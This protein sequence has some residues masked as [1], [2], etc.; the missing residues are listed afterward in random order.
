M[1][2]P[3]TRIPRVAF[4]RDTLAT[5]PLCG[6]KVK[7][8]SV[9]NPWR[10]NPLT[11][12][13]KVR[14]PLCKTWFPSN[15]YQRGDMTSGDYADDG[16]GFLYD[17]KRYFLLREYAHM[18]YGSVVIPTLRS[19]SQAYALTGDPKYARKGC[20]L[21]ARL[22]SE[23]PN[24]GWPDA[25]TALENRFDRT[26][27]GPWNNRH[28]HY[29]W[30]QGGM[31]T[32]LIWET[33]CLEATAYAYDGLFS[34]FDQDPDMI[35]FV[36]SKGMPV[37]SS[38]D[39]RAY[40]ETYI[41]RAA[42]HSLLNGWIKGNEGFH[43]AAALAVALVLDDYSDAH[44]NSR[45]LVDYAYHGLGHCAYVLVNGLTRDGGGHESPNYNMIK[46][47]FIRV[48]RVMELI[49][50]RHPERFPESRYPDLF[51]NPKARALFDYNIDILIQD[52]YLPSIGDCGGVQPPHRVTKRN[53]SLVK[54]EN[55]FAVQRYT[56]SRHARACVSPQGD[57][58][59][60]ELWE[61]YP[62]E[63]I[64][65]LVAAPESSCGRRAR[66]L[67]GYG[68]AIL[69]AGQH[70]EMTSAYLNYTSLRGHRQF[71][72]LSVGLYARGL[73]LLPDLGY[74]QTWD[75]RTRWDSNSLAHNTVTVDETQP[76]R[77]IGGTGRLFASLSGVHAIVAHHDPYPEG[78]RL[79]SPDAVP[80]DLY[81]RMLLMVETGNM[82]YV[83]DL[84]CV[85]GGEQHDQS[86]HGMLVAPECPNL[87]WE[88]Q[89]QGTL[90]G[91]DVPPFG[92]WTDRW[93][94]KRDDFPAFV[95]NVRC[96]PLTRPAS[97]TW[98]SGL[99][100][101][102]ALRLHIVP[103]N[104]PARV[105]MGDGRSPVWPKDRKLAYVLVRRRVEQG[106][107][108]RFLTVL[109]PFRE[110]ALISSIELLSEDPVAL[111]I[112]RAD[113]T[114]D[115]TLNLPIGP[116]RTTQLR[117]IGIRVMTRDSDG[118]CTR[119]VRIGSCN[120]TQD[121]SL[122]SAQQVDGYVTA[123]IEAVDYRKNEVAV[124]CDAKDAS[125]FSP[126]PTVRVHNEA[127][128]ALFELKLAPRR[129]GELIWLTLSH[130]A[131]FAQGPVE[132]VGEN[133]ITLDTHLTFASGKMG[134][135]G[136]RSGPAAFAGT[137]LG[138]GARAR[139][140]V[141]AARDGTVFLAPDPDETA[142]LPDRGETVSIWEYGVGDSIE[143][144]IVSDEAK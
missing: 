57:L 6:D 24:Y 25:D 65:E 63:T 114:D 39:L 64:R 133:R 126:G 80:V 20:I 128:S 96:A 14:C 47:D 4:P 117:P 52:Y 104:G 10:I 33:F 97:W 143:A 121:T 81:E 62:E 45:D 125:A 76:E 108:S 107:A 103:L 32:D 92:S 140:V 61:P 102:D 35:A 26:F 12:P 105:T 94:R 137:W 41:F 130:T 136:V 56:D 5:C 16:D 59:T 111:R 78:T 67:D 8:V 110:A 120:P 100:E 138:E 127:R 44:P 101:G 144:V 72:N 123:R 60:G 93:G 51:A 131:L 71:D 98:R 129:E 68:V 18:A 85:R 28:P 118:I 88:Q 142:D 79:G 19:L 17:G 7:K 15:D 106:T 37:D 134:K 2:Q 50:G 1:L 119:D 38:A 132:S 75:Y 21:L 86:W 49:R 29:R 22:A 84:F 40:I 30:K 83:V 46:L 82:P 99:P 3:T 54:K 23:Y 109:E 69:E 34:Y 77:S 112:T 113:G 115:I 55:V 48:A 13:Y 135:D 66:V 42:A 9:W 87:D 124:A 43:Q 116:S 89:A 53:A 139:R 122:S 27:L 73:N 74:P 141:C 70:P 90:A 91:P 31:I 58:F 36:R 95:S 11:H